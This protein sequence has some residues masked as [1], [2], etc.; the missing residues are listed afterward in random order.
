M[1]I[2]WYRTLFIAGAIAN[3]SITQEFGG[4]REGKT[5]YRVRCQKC[6][7]QAF[8]ATGASARWPTKLLRSSGRPTAAQVQFANSA[9]D[10]PGDGACKRPARAVANPDPSTMSRNRVHKEPM[11]FSQHPET[12]AAVG[13]A[14]ACVLL[15]GKIQPSA[16]RIQDFTLNPLKST[17]AS[18]SI[19][20]AHRVTK[21]KRP[22]IYK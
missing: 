7:D 19:T 20:P 22:L 6:V 4:E 15:H 5:T 16:I 21:T 1:D 2:A 9:R 12:C 3:G 17:Y 10:R 13:A 11:R 8:N 14:K 18:A